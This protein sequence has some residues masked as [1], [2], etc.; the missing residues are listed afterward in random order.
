[1]RK[2]TPKDEQSLFRRTSDLFFY[3]R[4]PWRPFDDQIFWDFCTESCNHVT[5]AL[6]GSLVIVFLTLKVKR[7][8][9]EMW[10]DGITKPARRCGA[11]QARSGAH[12][13][14]AAVR[15]QGLQV[16]KPSSFFKVM[17]SAHQ[18]SREQ[19]DGL[20]FDF[21]ASG[22]TGRGWGTGLIGSR[23]GP[24]RSILG[25]MRARAQAR[26][27][28]SHGRPTPSAAPW[29]VSSQPPRHL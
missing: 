9:E 10:T 5:G 14:P 25:S 3:L 28:W 20:P 22:R 6:I 8:H 23:P 2:M 21:Q 7:E 24:A 18:F 29:T 4:T 27:R 26:L 15:V 11:R 16:Q 12:T 13:G 1:M 19:A 17:I